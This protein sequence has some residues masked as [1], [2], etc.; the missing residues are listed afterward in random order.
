MA[1]LQAETGL[2]VSEAL[3]VAKNFDKYYNPRSGTIE[4]VIGKGN[5]AYAPKAIDHHL[6]KE[7]QKMATIPHYNTYRKDLK[8]VG[9]EKSHDFRVTY[10]K[11]LLDIIQKEQPWHT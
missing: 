8:Q 10:A 2:R 5:H 6:A 7:I 4:N 11:N 3:E 1:K 9:I